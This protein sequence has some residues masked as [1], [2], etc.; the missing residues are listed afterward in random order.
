VEYEIRT[1]Q[2]KLDDSGDGRRGNKNRI[3]YRGFGQ[4]SII[5]DEDLHTSTWL[6]M[7]EYWDLSLQ[8]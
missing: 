6:G 1:E 2:W 7:A 8:P 5:R 4:S 3:R